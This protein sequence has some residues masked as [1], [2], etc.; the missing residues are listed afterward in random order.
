MRYRLLRVMIVI[1]SSRLLFWVRWKLDKVA[2][3]RLR[4]QIKHFRL[5]TIINIK[6]ILFCTFQIMSRNINTLFIYQHQLFSSMQPASYV[7]RVRNSVWQLKNPNRPQRGTY[8]HP[9]VLRSR[10]WRPNLNSRTGHH[11]TSVM[12]YDPKSPILEDAYINEW[13]SMGWWSGNQL[14]RIGGKWTNLI[15]SSPCSK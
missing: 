9:A 8:I 4:E 1:T 6:V 12:G 11:S 7:R 5:Y 10:L 15:L 13:T 3:W 14:L 2:W